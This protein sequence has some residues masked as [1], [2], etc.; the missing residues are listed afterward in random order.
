MQQ[1]PIYSDGGREILPHGTAAFPIGHYSADLCAAP[2]PF[3]WHRE[4]ETGFVTEGEVCM[5][6][7]GEKLRLEKGDGFFINSGVPHGFSAWQDTAVS[8]QR[9]LVFEASLV[10]GSPGSVFWQ[11]YVQPILSAAGLP[12]LVL[13]RPVPWQGRALDLVEEV[14]RCTRDQG[15]DYEI[16]A[17]YA[18][19]NLAALLSA[20]LPQ[21]EPGEAR[22]L[23]RDHER[24]RTMLAFIQENYAQPIDASDIAASAMISS[25][26]AL[27]CFHHTIGMTPVQYLKSYR[28]RK[29]AE[30]LESTDGQISAVAYACGF[31]DMSYF[32][33]SFRELMGVLPGQYRRQY[34]SDLR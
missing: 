9:S 23:S 27:R 11:K 13:Q 26:E 18:L 34:G 22:R 3:H 4:L 12:W 25:S 20:H 7:G 10:G 33:R 6:V 16:E 29:A 21:E 28:L 30:L 8:R 14:W 32:S 24:I 19:T 17:R 31:R 15:E 2:V 5:R 1:L